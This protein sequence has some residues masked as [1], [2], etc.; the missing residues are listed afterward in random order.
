V[1]LVGLLLLGDVLF[2][3]LVLFN[4]LLLSVLTFL[5]LIS[6]LSVLL[7]ASLLEVLLVVVVLV[8]SLVLISLRSWSVLTLI[9]ISVGHLWDEHLWLLSIEIES[10]DLG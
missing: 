10:L 6:V 5:L 3:A 1:R 4:L 8:P 9:L 7:W 2:L